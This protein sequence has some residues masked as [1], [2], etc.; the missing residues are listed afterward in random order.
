MGRWFA[1]F[2]KRKGNT[3]IISGRDRRKASRVARS[4]GVEA[5]GS[6][7]DAVGGADLVIISVLPPYLERVLRE[8]SPRLTE[9]QRVIDITSIKAVPVRL[10]HRYIK[11]SVVLG[12]HPMFGPSADTKGQNFILTPTNAKEKR[13]ARELGRMLSD[14]GFSVRTTTPEKHDAMIG[15][16]LSL[17]HFIGFVTADT[18]KTLRMER[19]INA[20]S[21]SFKFLLKFA[22]SV[23]DSDP[24][25]YSYIQMDVP[26]SSKAESAFVKQARMW[27]GIVRKRDRSRFE[28]RMNELSRYLERLEI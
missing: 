18:W 13:F 7:I 21:T 25:L 16:I 14:Y 5:A 2:L 12:T 17:T 19:Y 23:V 28:A 4:I 20:S 22:K 3:V 15:Y 1:A 27:S 11:R 10:M 26:T 24:G 8:I 9:K 6:N